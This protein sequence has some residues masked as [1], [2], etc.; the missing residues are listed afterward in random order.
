MLRCVLRCFEAVTELRMNFGNSM[1]IKVG[2]V[3]NIEI[4]AID[5]GYKVDNLLI[6]YLGL[7]LGASFKSKVWGPVM[8]RVRR[9]LVG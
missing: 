7:P 2:N 1:I 3:P 9:K 5:L 6:P 8:D 4:L